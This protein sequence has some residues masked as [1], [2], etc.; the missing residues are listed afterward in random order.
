[1]EELNEYFSNSDEI[2]ETLNELMIKYIKNLADISYNETQKTKNLINNMTLIISNK[3][4]EI[5]KNIKNYLINSKNN[6]IQ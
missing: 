1:M 2:D 5:G 4:L 3:I 6:K